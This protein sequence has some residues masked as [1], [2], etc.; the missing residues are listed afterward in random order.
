MHLRVAPLR[1]RGAHVLRHCLV[2]AAGP[3]QTAAPV[4][5]AAGLAAPGQGEAAVARQL[6]I[7]VREHVALEGHHPRAHLRQLCRCRLTLRART[8]TP[9][10]QLPHALLQLLRLAPQPPIFLHQLRLRLGLRGSVS[11]VGGLT[12]SATVHCH[13]RGPSDCV[14]ASAGGVRLAVIW[15]LLGGPRRR[16]AGRLGKRGQ[17]AVSPCQ[18]LAL[19]R[20]VPS[21]DV[22]GVGQWLCGGGCLRVI[23]SADGTHDAPPGSSALALLR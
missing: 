13:H 17:S 16:C 12:Q 4:R 19:A 21:Q 6:A 10:P 20:L 5:A 14:G 15:A 23:G 2:E 22:A 9:L 8:L 3:E 18:H 11:P 7:H 1:Q